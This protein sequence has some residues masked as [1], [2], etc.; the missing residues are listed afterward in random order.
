MEQQEKIED[1]LE[2]D[3]NLE[4]A[5]NVD[6]SILQEAKIYGVDLDKLEQFHFEVGSEKFEHKKRLESWK[7]LDIGLADVIKM[8]VETSERPTFLVRDDILEY[9][10][11]AAISIL[12][13][14]ADTNIVGSN[15]FKLV[16]KE[17][18]NLLAEN[19]GEMITNVKTVRI[20]L[21]SLDGKIVPIN[22]QAIYLSDIEHFSFILLGDHVRKE[23]RSSFNNLYDDVTGLPNFFLFEDRLQVAIS[24]EGAKEN[25]QRASTVV[26]AAISI[27][28]IEVFR[29]MHIEEMIIKKVANNLVLNLPKNSTVA[30]GLKYNFWILFSGIGSKNDTNQYVKRVFDVLKEGVSDNFTQHE[31]LFSIGVSSFPYPARSAKR[32]IEQA[33]EA[34]KEAQANPKSSIKFYTGKDV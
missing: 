34:I 17:D 25:S 24:L 9:I 21:K 2:G 29:K 14:K 33:I 3:K 4:L 5:G 8:I 19:I 23:A 15:F 18:R 6:K 30:R 20:R 26:V 12:S 7:S 31:L 16:V 13:L 11:P 28:N 1:F 10:N 32:T 22:F 27:D